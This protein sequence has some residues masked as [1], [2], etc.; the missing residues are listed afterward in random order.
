MIEF[1]RKDRTLSIRLSQEEYDTLQRAAQVHRSRT[2]SDFARDK[3]FGSVG[4]S[5]IESR[6]NQLQT[7]LESVTRDLEQLRTALCSS[8]PVPNGE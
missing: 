4:P 2:V 6:V 7:E 3:L 8:T 5:A 1:G